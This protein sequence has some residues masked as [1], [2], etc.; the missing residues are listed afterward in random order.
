MKL[1]DNE[2]TNAEKQTQATQPNNNETQI[3]EKFAEMEDQMKIKP[4]TEKNSKLKLISSAVKMAETERFR[5]NASDMIFSS[6]EEAN[7]III[8]EPLISIVRDCTFCDE[9]FDNYDD[10]K[11]HSSQ[12]DKLLPYL[13]ASVDFYRCSR[14]LFVF[15]NIDDLAEHYKSENCKSPEEID[16]VEY[17]DESD[18]NLPAIRLFSCSKNPNN[19]LYV[20]DVCQVDFAELIDFRN[21]FDVFH[22]NNADQNIGYLLIET[23]HFCGIC[24]SRSPLE[25]LKSALHHVYFHQRDFKCPVDNCMIAFMRFMDLYSHTIDEHSLIRN[26]NCLHCSFSTK[27]TD[28]LKVHNQKSCKAR[29]FECNECGSYIFSAIFGVGF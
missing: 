23:P 10:M 29:N 13:L 27:S 7:E 24:K 9:T 2:Q 18:G 21:H 17:L 15:S 14:C 12:H 3:D 8:G 22:S 28:E 16:R 20:C 5:L 25:N 11:L 6:N 26:Y 19:N 4:S 1:A